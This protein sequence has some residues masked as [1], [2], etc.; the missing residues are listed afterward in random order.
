MSEIEDVRRFGTCEC[1]SNEITDEQTEYYVCSE[2][3]V[4]CS[5]ECCLEY[6][7]IEKIEV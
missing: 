6:Y 5:V 7:G 4:F 1:C 3:H 2:G